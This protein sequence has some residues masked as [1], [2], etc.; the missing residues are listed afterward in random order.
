MLKKSLK[1]SMIIVGSLLVIV[2][3]FFTIVYFKTEARINKV[4]AVT[5]QKITVPTDS[6]SYLAGKHIAENRGCLGCH[7]DNLAGGRA[8]ADEQSPIGLLYAANITAGKGGIQ[9]TDE[10][11]VRV[12]RHGLAKSN[13][14]AWFMPSQDIYHISNQELG[15]LISFVKSFPPVD[16][17]V[18]A[19]SL[20]PLG[21]ILTFLGKFP[22]LPAEMIDHN[23]VFK[24]QVVAGVN[25]TYGA[26]LA[27]TCRGCHGPSMKGSSAHDPKEPPIPDI[28]STGHPGK[29]APA[30]FITAIRTG[31]T[32]EGKH[33]DEAMPWKHLTFTDDELN[34]IFLYLQGIK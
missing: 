17:T 26:Y 7:G 31:N 8:F 24:E 19:K 13:K 4:Y 2:I 14:S 18:P 27:T 30:G 11:W 3:V 21:R 16:N 32:P 23:T 1:W 29:W 10:D 33:L 25:A 15:E 20:K 9:Y 5:L 12:I 28:S 6:V 34:A 22:L